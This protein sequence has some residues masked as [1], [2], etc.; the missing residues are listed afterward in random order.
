MRLALLQ[1]AEEAS[2]VSVDGETI[3]G[4]VVVFL[5]IGAILWAFNR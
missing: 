3:L 2:K 4:A 5:A 1:A